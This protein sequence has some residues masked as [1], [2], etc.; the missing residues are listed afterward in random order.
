MEALQQAMGLSELD[1]DNDKVISSSRDYDK[2]KQLQELVMKTTI[3]PKPVG[4]QLWALAKTIVTNGIVIPK[5]H[6][7]VT[8]VSV[9]AAVPRGNTDGSDINDIPKEVFIPRNLAGEWSIEKLFYTNSNPEKPH[10]GVYMA[11]PVSYYDYDDYWQHVPT[12]IRN[13]IPSFIQKYLEKYAGGYTPGVLKEEHVSVT[14]FSMKCNLNLGDVDEIA[15]HLEDVHGVK[16]GPTKLN[17]FREITV[18]AQLTFEIPKMV[19][20]ENVGDDKKL[21]KIRGLYVLCQSRDV[22]SKTNN[23]AEAFLKEERSKEFMK[24]LSNACSEIFFSRVEEY[25]REKVKKDITESFSC[26]WTTIEE[27]ILNAVGR[28]HNISKVDSFIDKDGTDFHGC[29]LDILFNRIS[30]YV[31]ER[32][33]TDTSTFKD[34]KSR[35]ISGYTFSTKWKYTLIIR[36]I[37]ALPTTFAPIKEHLRQEAADIFCDLKQLKDI[38]DF[39]KELKTFFKTNGHLQLFTTTVVPPPSNKKL[40]AN[41]AKVED[42][43][44]EDSPE[45]KKEFNDNFEK[46]KVPANVEIKFKKE[47]LAAM[48]KLCNDTNSTT[49][50]ASLQEFKDFCKKQKNYACFCCLSIN[51]LA[52]QRAAKAAKMRKVFNNKCGKKKL[53]LG[54]VKTIANKSKPKKEEE[55]TSTGATASISSDNEP[56]DPVI[57][58]IIENFVVEENDS[59][60]DATFTNCMAEVNLTKTITQET[61]Q[62]RFQYWSSSDKKAMTSDKTCIICHK[63][64]MNWPRYANHL[65]THE[66]YMVEDSVSYMSLLDIDTAIEARN[67]EL[68]SP[69]PRYYDSVN[70]QSISEFNSASEDNS[71]DDETPKLIK[72]PMRK[73]IEEI[74]ISNSSSD[75]EDCQSDSS[76]RSKPSRSRQQVSKKLK[77]VSNQVETLN[78]NIG[79]FEGR[80]LGIE[81]NVRNIS[82]DLESMNSMNNS[83]NSALKNSLEK[84][85]KTF[86][87]NIHQVQSEMKNM[88]VS[89][90]NLEMGLRK[91]QELSKNLDDKLM[92]SQVEQKKLHEESSREIQDLKKTMFELITLFK[93]ERR[94]SNNQSEIVEIP[95]RKNS[96]TDLI[97]TVSSA[98]TCI[99]PAVMTSPIESTV[100]VTSPSVAKRTLEEAK[101]EEIAHSTPAPIISNTI[102]VK[103]LDIS[104]AQVPMEDKIQDSSIQA[105]TQSQVSSSRLISKKT[106]KKSIK[107]GSRKISKNKASRK[108]ES[109]SKPSQ[110]KTLSSE[111]TL[112]MFIR[113]SFDTIQDVNSKCLEAFK[114]FTSL[115]KTPSGIMYIMLLIIM[116]SVGVSKAAA[117]DSQDNFLSTNPF[118]RLQPDQ[119]MILFDASSMGTKD[120]LFDLGEVNNGIHTGINS[121]CIAIQAMKK[122]CALH[123]E[124]C[125]AANLAIMNLESAIEKYLQTKNALQRVCSAG[126][127]SSSKEI[128]RR[129]QA[130]EN[131]EEPRR[132]KR[133]IPSRSIPSSTAVPEEDFPRSEEFLDDDSLVERIKRFV[134]SG[135]ILLAT[136]FGVASLATAAGTAAV[137]ANNQANKVFKKVQG[138]R[139]EDIKNS[140]INDK[141][142]LGLIQDTGSDLDGVRE[143]TTLSTHA[144]T[145]LNQ[146]IDMENKFSHLVSRSGTIEFSDPSQEIFMQAIKEMNSWDTEGLTR[147]EIGQ[148]TRVSADITTLTTFIIPTHSSSARCEHRMVLKTIFVPVINHRSRRVVVTREGR[149]FPKFGDNSRYILLSSNSMLSKRT[150][151]FESSARIVGKSCSIHVSVNATVSPSPNPLFEDYHFLLPGNLTITETCLNNSTNPSK[152]WIISSDT[153]IRLPLSCSLQ[154]TLINCNSIPIQSGDKQVVHFSNHRMRIIEQHWNEEKL[155]FNESI[156][157]QSKV[158]IDI[159]ANESTF[160]FLESLDNHKIP[161]IGSGGAAVMMVIILIIIITAIKCH[162]GDN[163]TPTPLIVQTTTTTTPM[164]TATA[165]SSPVVTTT[166]PISCS[167]PSYEESEYS[168]DPEVIRNIDALNRN[169]SQIAIMRKHS[170]RKKAK[171]ID[172]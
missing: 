136:A 73:R 40:S 54:E 147:N 22:I 23:K 1:P 171:Q 109:D 45:K 47:I 29:P 95:N 148:K 150:K 83:G 4:P 135:A 31:D 118:T 37:R 36:L 16:G 35:T 108:E 103:H 63:R 74:P 81:D 125:Q 107:M 64:K 91:S 161:I 132:G 138:N 116:G 113:R 158:E 75:S 146:A 164:I 66:V 60:T 122:Q 162:K 144:Q 25:I 19:D 53:T 69:D 3:A 110:E 70:E 92:K 126:E 61:V 68:P 133:Y 30:H 128:I 163:T 172:V 67:E 72:L 129:C 20:I 65:E 18:N 160:S 127:I 88:S 165:T 27:A 124:N 104:A 38:T 59:E 42:E 96:E 43:T 51:C 17:P 106:S 77:D 123:P 170:M 33:G 167:P 5:C 7:Q 120:F 154:S 140:I 2:R 62:T 76:I 44:K 24:E 41:N 79:N 137:V 119:N 117:I 84:N 149:I 48:S 11:A 86:K 121:S 114:D 155:N 26:K 13:A 49:E 85:A 151:L 14:F 159:S 102:P 55:G 34:S 101:K 153:K 100:I 130:G 111:S 142:V 169:P 50:V 9:S 145:N 57:N 39:I 6:M 166:V 141:F 94:N 87:E 46:T 89:S 71:D 58:D 93:E 82:T 10:K 21:E 98:K 97:G 105:R 90:A 152:E 139:A 56:Y 8:V 134:I 99:P 52:K 112:E 156:F 15:E 12:N 115:F 32:C 157:V 80:L 168:K 143:I 78:E 28:E 131:W